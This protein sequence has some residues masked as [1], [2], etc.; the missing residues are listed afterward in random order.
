[1]RAAFGVPLVPADQR[2]D[3]SGFGVKGFEAEV[4]GGEVELLVVGGVVRDVHF[5][6]DA[7]HGAVGIEDGGSVMVNTGGAAFKEGRNDDDTGF[8]RY[9]AESFGGRAGDRLGEVEIGDVFPLAKVLR[10]KEFRQADD[11]GAFGSG[12]F[13]EFAC[14]LQIVAGFGADAHLDESHFKFIGS[15]HNKNL[16]EFEV[17]C[18]ALGPARR[19]HF[20]VSRI[21]KVYLRK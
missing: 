9:F 4:A 16:H 2:G 12:L 3:L 6:V 5:A 11:L 20:R 17:R 8:L 19:P 1:M 10:L 18:Y 21:A 14:A 15:G 7:R 13:D